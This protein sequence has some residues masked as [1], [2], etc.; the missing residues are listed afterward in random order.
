MQT[1]MKTDVTKVKLITDMFD[2]ID[3]QTHID[4]FHPHVRKHRKVR[5]ALDGAM[6][7]DLLDYASPGTRNKM[8]IEVRDTV[9]IQTGASRD[10]VEGY[11]FAACYDAVREYHLIENN[12][13]SYNNEFWAAA[14]GVYSSAMIHLAEH[15]DQQTS[16]FGTF[17]D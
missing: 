15:K 11:E 4:H 14:W 5:D 13:K 10:E 8:I 16:M 7:C 9:E 6:M 1:T 12:G 2:K 17:F 3:L